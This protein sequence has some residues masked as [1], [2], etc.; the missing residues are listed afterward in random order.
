MKAHHSAETAK[1][2]HDQSLGDLELL[3]ASYVTHHFAPHTHE[4]YAIGVIEAGAETF[5]YRHQLHIAPAGSIVLINPGEL[6]TGEPLN[7]DG[8]RYRMLYPGTDVLQQAASEIAGR[9]LGVP[10][11]AQPVVRDASMARLLLAL[12]AAIEDGE[13]QLER[14]S[15][16]MWTMGQLVARHA[17]DRLRVQPMRNEQDAVLRVRDHFGDHFHERV[18]LAQLAQVANMS[19]FHL[20]RIFRQATGLPPHAYL[21]QMRVAHAKRL[22]REGLPIADVALKTGFTDQSH[23][24]R[25]FKRIVGVTPGRYLGSMR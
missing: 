1:Y 3:R 5:T 4:G 25:H 6:H 24:N 14:E 11:F 8:W 13:S 17:D 15:R 19:A 22:L 16:L 23:L 20:L 7:G 12:H 9:A 18:T 10:F 2:W 21:T